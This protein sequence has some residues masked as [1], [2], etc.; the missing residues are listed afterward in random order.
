MK[1]P[2][3][4]RVLLYDLETSLEAVTVFSLKYN[5][6]IDP[7]A[8]IRERTIICA[9]WLWLGEKTV[10]SVSVLDNPRLFAKDPANDRHVVEVLHGIMSQ[11]DVVVGHNSDNFDDKYLKTRILF[12]GLPALP[13]IPSIDTYKVAKSHLLFN[14]NK[15]NYIGKYLGV[16]QKKHTTSGLWMRAFNGERKAIQEMVAYNKQDVR[17][18]ERVFLKL[19]PYIANHLNRQLWGQTGCPRC[20]SHR[21]QSRGLHRAIS[22]VYRRWNCQAC[23]GWYRSAVNDKTFH[24]SSRIL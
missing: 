5:D 15:L 1:L 11:A 2:R 13:P 12:H 24:A 3:A 9:S 10:H 4:P 20:G 23:G 14:S 19:R 7:D 6:F 21:V 17:L 22:R 8:I 18:L 16:G